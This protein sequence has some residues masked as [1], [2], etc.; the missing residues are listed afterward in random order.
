M[1][2]KTKALLNNQFV[3]Y[4]LVFIAGAALAFAYNK[5][6]IDTLEEKISSEKKTFEEK[7]KQAVS[8]EKERSFAEFQQ[9]IKTAQKNVVTVT[10]EK[11]VDGTVITKTV[12]DKSTSA[13]NTSKKTEEKIKEVVTVV[14]ETK[15]Q[16]VDKIVVQEKKVVMQPDLPRYMVGAYAVSGIKGL[17]LPPTYDYDAK[18]GVRLFGGL[19]ATAGYRLKTQE[20]SAGLMIQF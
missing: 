20:L 2:E 19:W 16:Y 1:N 5:Q 18:V 11:R 15:I 8:E 14:T 17:L 10:V 7:I 4:V 13:K 6:S 12:I 9:A 3:R